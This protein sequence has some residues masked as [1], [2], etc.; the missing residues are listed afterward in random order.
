VWWYYTRQRAAM[1]ESMVRELTA[2]S[3]SKARQI[4]SWRSERLGDGHVQMAA[5]IVRIAA[6]ILA[7]RGT[8]S[9]RADL[10]GFV[11]LWCLLADLQASFQVGLIGGGRMD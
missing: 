2:V 10:L 8:S 9:D 5:P 3:E 7:G 4:A 6:R 1:Q 11:R